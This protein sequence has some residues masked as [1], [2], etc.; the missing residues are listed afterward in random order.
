[1]FCHTRVDV[2]IVVALARSNKPWRID[3]VNELEGVL[4]ARAVLCL[5][6]RHELRELGLK[7]GEVRVGVDCALTLQGAASL[8][9]AHKCD[10]VRENSLT[11]FSQVV[12]R[13]PVDETRLARRMVADDHHSQPVARRHLLKVELTASQVLQILGDLAQPLEIRVAGVPLVDL[14]NLAQNIL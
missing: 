1:M 11:S 5:K 2:L 4:R 8:A 14:D 9:V 6:A 13:V 7:R 10:C 12:A 3:E